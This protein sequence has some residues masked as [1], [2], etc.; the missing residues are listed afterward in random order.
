[1][2]L[3]IQYIEERGFAGAIWSDDPMDCQGGQFK[4]IVVQGPHAAKG[5]GKIS[6]F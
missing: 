6:N 5:F 2:I 4:G 3:S 1:M